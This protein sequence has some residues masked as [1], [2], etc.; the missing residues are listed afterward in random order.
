MRP[1]PSWTVNQRGRKKEGQGQ[2]PRREHQHLQ[3]RREVWLMRK[4]TLWSLAV[5]PPTQ[6]PQ[7]LTLPTSQ[8]LYGLHSAPGS[9][10]LALGLTVLDG[11]PVKPQ[12]RGRVW[13]TDMVPHG[14]AG[15][16]GLLWASES[17]SV[18][19]DDDGRIR[20]E[21]FVVGARRT[22][23]ASNSDCTCLGS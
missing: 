5:F 2:N 15:G 10:K 23:A 1:I 13:E 16:L 9:G 22:S 12:C 4:R 19:R 6:L 14:G 8:A 7:G 20:C 11:R 17:F 21:H 3:S 18:R